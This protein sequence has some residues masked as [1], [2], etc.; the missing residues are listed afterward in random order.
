MDEHEFEIVDDETTKKGIIALAGA[1]A[2]GALAAWGG[3]K[4]FRGAKK[5]IK[6]AKADR[7]QRKRIK[8]EAKAKA[9]EV[10]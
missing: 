2:V 9:D 7:A 3:P 5:R 4:L 6:A 8:S 1:A 10:G